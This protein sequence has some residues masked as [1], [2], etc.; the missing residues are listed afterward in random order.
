MYIKAN[1]QQ[2]PNASR[3]ESADYMD[4]YA[5][6][7][8]SLYDSPA[9]TLYED[10][11]ELIATYTLSEMRGIECVGNRLRLYKPSEL[12]SREKREQAYETRACVEYDGQT[13]TVDAANKLYLAYSAEGQ[14]ER[15]QALSTLIAVAKAGIRA[16]FPD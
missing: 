12:T 4:L 15:A 6:G 8:A 13:L 7:I 11:D 3:V 14:M 9:I 5:D 1:E 10:N 2:F 16:E